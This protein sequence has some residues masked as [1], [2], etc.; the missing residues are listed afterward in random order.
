MPEVRA[1]LAHPP[2]AQVFVIGQANPAGRD[3]IPEIGHVLPEKRAAVRGDWTGRPQRRVLR[4]FG[5]ADL[6]VDMPGQWPYTGD[7]SKPLS[8]P[9]LP[10][11][12]V[13]FISRRADRPERL[14]L[15]AADGTLSNTFGAAD[16]IDSLRPVLAAAGM[17]ITEDGAVVR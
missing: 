12:A 2:H 16:T 15:F 1:T 5:R 3:V 10:A 17:T 4:G 6:V 11:N 9:A 14:A 7:M 13:G 8:I